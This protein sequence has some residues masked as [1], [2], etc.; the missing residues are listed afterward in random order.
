MEAPKPIEKKKPETQTPKKDEK[1]KPTDNGITFKMIPVDE[2]PKRTFFRGSRYYSILE[3]FIK[4]PP[5]NGL[6]KIQDLHGKTG[7][8]ITSQINKQIKSHK[9]TEKVKVSCVSGV[10]YL[11]SKKKA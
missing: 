11:E 10:V 1:P 2:I 8:Y 3:D 5:V 4:T 9:L 7:N 6:S